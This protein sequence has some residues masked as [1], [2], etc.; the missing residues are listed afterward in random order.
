MT[1]FNVRYSEELSKGGDWKS[2]PWICSP[3]SSDRCLHV[4]FRLRQVRHGTE[5]WPICA[6]KRLFFFGWNES[7]SDI[8]IVEEAQF[9]YPLLSRKTGWLWMEMSDLV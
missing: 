4:L 2:D 1:L 3:S 8:V 6:H 7:Q 5:H 9:M